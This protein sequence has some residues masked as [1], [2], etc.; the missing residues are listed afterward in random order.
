MWAKPL[1]QIS[2]DVPPDTK[3]TYHRSRAAPST[4]EALEG[5]GRGGG[6]VADREEEQQQIGRK[7][8]AGA[9]PLQCEKWL[10]MSLVWV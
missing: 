5:A 7:V 1:L 8:N 6:G 3:R 10:E 4:A 2:F 9:G